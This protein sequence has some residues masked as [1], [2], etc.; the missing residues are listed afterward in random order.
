MYSLSTCR[1]IKFFVSQYPVYVEALSFYIMK[2]THNTL[3]LMSVVLPLKIAFLQLF[4]RDNFFI[5]FIQVIV[6]DCFIACGSGYFVLQHIHKSQVYKRGLIYAFRSGLFSV[7]VYFDT[8]Y[9]PI[10]FSSCMVISLSSVLLGIFTLISI[11]MIANHPVSTDCVFWR[12]VW[13]AITVVCILIQLVEFLYSN[14]ESSPYLVVVIIILV[15]V[16]VSFIIFSFRTVFA[17]SFLIVLVIL[18]TT[19]KYKV[20][21]T[22]GGDWLPV[23][24]G[25]LRQFSLVGLLLYV[26]AHEL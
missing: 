8:A 10:L 6:M 12:K 22:T 2:E 17:A 19:D 23:L 21:N 16:F 9:P 26:I 20:W 18:H 14:N 13:K 7:V 1:S 25:F 5:R 11:K 24:H 4:I 15:F 3:L